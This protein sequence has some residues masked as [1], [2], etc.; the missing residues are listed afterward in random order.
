MKEEYSHYK[1][2]WTAQS[3]KADHEATD[4][5]GVVWLHE[6]CDRELRLVLPQLLPAENKPHLPFR[7][8][9]K[10]LDKKK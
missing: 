9:L 2:L 5:F 4:N 3:L 7:N 10:H 6:D 8:A 1:D